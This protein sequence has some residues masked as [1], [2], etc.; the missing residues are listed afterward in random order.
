MF[1]EMLISLSFNITVNLVWLEPAS[2]NASKA[3]PPVKAPSPITAITLFFSPFMS[4]ALAI[5]N[6][7]DIEVLLCPVLK[8]SVS[9]S[10]VFGNPAIPFSCLKV[11]NC[12][13][14]P[15]IILCT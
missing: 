11:F 10:F 3:I 4:L 13:L 15:V 1:F 5:P 14:L 8:Q 12:S 7:A 9:D 6:A 2:F